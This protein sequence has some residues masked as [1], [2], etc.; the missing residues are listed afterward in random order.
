M[1]SHQCIKSMIHRHQS[2]AQHLIAFAGYAR[3]QGYQT[4]IE[5]VAVALQS[6]TL[7]DLSDREAFLRVLSI[8]FSSTQ[9][10]WLE[11]RDLY[12]S[13]WQEY[14]RAVNAKVKHSAEDTVRKRPEKPA[15]RQIEDIK[16]W[17][18]RHHREAIQTAF[19]SPHK[20]IDKK[21]LST[22]ELR[23]QKEL[24]LWLKIFARKLA[25]SASRKIISHPSKGKL[26]LR[27]LLK[28][29]FRR[30]DELLTLRYRYRRKDKSKII[31]MCDVSRSMDLFSH[32]L[33]SLM[34]GLY[35]CFEHCQIY[36]FNTSLIPLKDLPRKSDFV[37]F[38]KTLGAVPG[39]W[40][41][42]TRIGES[43][44]QLN[45]LMLPRWY[46]QKTKVIIYSDGW[47]TGDIALLQREV[48][49]LTQNSGTTIWLNPV[50]K[51]E[52]TIQ[53]AAMRGIRSVVD[54]LV[55]VRNL[56]SLKNFIKDL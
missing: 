39:L 56:H 45:T 4:G 2:L 20:S 9:K 36:L 37:A 19:Y 40:T 38:K 31:L 50:I 44:E 54:H 53:T 28:N 49:R 43:L 32:F 13:F 29:R 22:L 55:P 42:G 15:F 12:Q 17:L 14:Q 30:G 23:D 52:E 41:G 6:C 51:D 27:I 34:R 3:R 8:C 1:E 24:D 18:Y 7:I 48:I 47:D 33:M 26:D 25:R 10:Q 35:T 16:R 46:D 5:G 11:I 21:D